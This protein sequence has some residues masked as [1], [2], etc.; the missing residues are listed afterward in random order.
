MN[1]MFSCSELK[2]LILNNWYIRDD[3]D[4]LDGKFIF[5]EFYRCDKLEELYL[6]GWKYKNFED[7]IHCLP[8]GSIPRKLYYNDDSFEASTFRPPSWEFIRVE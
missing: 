2:T 1:S 7:I 6:L 5:D 3:E 4:A 8:T